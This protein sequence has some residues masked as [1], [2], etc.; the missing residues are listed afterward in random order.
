ML[1]SRTNGEM[2][3]FKGSIGCLLCLFFVLRRDYETDRVSTNSSPLFHPMFWSHFAESAVISAMI[4]AILRVKKFRHLQVRGWQI[5]R[6]PLHLLR[7]LLNNQF[8]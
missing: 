6:I 3:N 7:R 8:D 4:Q 2:N 5:N 1:K